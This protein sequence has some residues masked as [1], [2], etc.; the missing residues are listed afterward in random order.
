MNWEKELNPSQYEAANYINGQLLILAGAGSGKTKTL[1]HRICHMIEAGINPKNILAITF[2]NKAAKEMTDRIS[3]LIGDVCKPKTCTFHSLGFDIIKEFGE[4]IGYKP[5]VGI[6]DDEDTKKRVKR[7]LELVE[8]HYEIEAGSLSKNKILVKDVM[9]YISRCK[10]RCLGPDD[11]KQPN[12]VEENMSTFLV[13]RE[14]YVEAYSFY[15]AELERDNQVDFDDLIYKSVLLLRNNFVASTLSNRYK[16]ISV[17]EYQDTSHAQF[18]MVHY[19]VGENKNIC[20]VGDDY[21]SI[22]A[23]RGADISNILSFKEDYPDAKVVT[24]GENYRSTGNIVDGASAVILNNVNQMKKNLFSMNEQGKPIT[25]AEFEDYRQEAKYV[26]EKISKGLSNGRTENDYA[27][28]YRNNFLSRYMEDALI[29]A[30][31][32]YIIY[33]GVSFYSRKEIKDIVSYLRLVAGYDDSV[34]LERIINIP[35]RGIGKKAQSDIMEYIRHEQGDLI[36]KLKNYLPLNKKEKYC[37]FVNLLESANAHLEDYNLPDILQ[38]VVESVN[39]FE[40]LDSEYGKTKSKDTDESESFE[41]KSNVFELI[42]KA[43]EFEDD[44]LEEFPESNSIDV[45]NAF[46]ESISLLTDADRNK[47]T[48]PCVKLMTMHSSKGLEFRN[49]F[50]VGCEYDTKF[51]SMSL[52]ERQNSIEEERRLFYV[53]MTRAKKKLFITYADARD[54]FGKYTYREPSMFI[55]EIPNKNVY[56]KV[57]KENSH[58]QMDFL[59]SRFAQLRRN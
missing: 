16:Y 19:L 17:D 10:D 5:Y 46:L 44:Y 37:Q 28:L 55:N 6:C 43:R 34:S 54:M 22:Y 27:I 30:G 48:E 31:I 47:S 12:K 1:T 40:Y 11:I 4:L 33:G 14:L 2:T 18:Q 21:Q 56:K 36:S 26:V 57:Q 59:S 8:K 25:I 52:E 42:A 3:S 29:S 13:A 23:F 7:A 24:L 38:T 50:M 15:Q 49:V 9:T 58:P 39:Y 32:K 53:A 51:D 35:K 20:V 41:R 45:L